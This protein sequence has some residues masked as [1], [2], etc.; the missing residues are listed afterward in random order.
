MHKMQ[1]LIMFIFLFVLVASC[2][3]KSNYKQYVIDQ[4]SID[5]TK[6]LN[7][8]EVRAFYYNYNVCKSD[9][10]SILISKRKKLNDEWKNHIEK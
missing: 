9:L 8:S 1:K 2:R 3:N 7:S 10:S 6:V 5:S 4:T